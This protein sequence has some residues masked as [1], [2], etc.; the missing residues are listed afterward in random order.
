M[1]AVVVW[2][3]WWWC[4]SCG[5]G[6]VAAVVWKLWWWCVCVGVILGVKWIFIS[7]LPISVNNCRYRKIIT[8]I[9]KSNTDNENSNSLYM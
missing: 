7:Y 6:V 5:G 9:G 3:L 4:G 2:K 1:V 8:D